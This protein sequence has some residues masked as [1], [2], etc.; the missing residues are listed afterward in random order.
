MIW[1]S[2]MKA[3]WRKDARKAEYQSVRMVESSWAS[4]GDVIDDDI[5]DSVSLRDF[6]PGYDPSREPLLCKETDIDL[7]KDSMII[8]LTHDYLPSTIML[9]LN[10]VIESGFLKHNPTTT[11]AWD[12]VVLKV[13]FLKRLI[14]VDVIQRVLF[15]SIY[16]C[17]ARFYF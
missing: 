14:V 3:L 10:I 7:G 15:I 2:L 16:T 1:S 6:G 8:L 4:D 11:S 5:G 13:I 12:F 17:I 9:Q